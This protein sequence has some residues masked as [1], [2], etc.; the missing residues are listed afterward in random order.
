MPPPVL[1]I[2]MNWRKLIVVLDHIRTVP[3]DIRRARIG[4]DQST[5][6]IRDPLFATD[7]LQ[8]SLDK[9]AWDV[10]QGNGIDAR[11]NVDTSRQLRLPLDT[12]VIMYNVPGDDCTTVEFVCM[13][14][15]GLL[16]DTL[17]FLEPTGLNV[18]EA[19]ITTINNLA[20]NIF[21]VQRANAPLG[22]NELIY[23]QNV[24]EHDAKNRFDPNQSM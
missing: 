5:L 15:I 22:H 3:L 13:D 4:A 2:R 9:L 1:T 14:R 7:D 21:H 24:F 6:Y 20:H 11:S 19:H 12:K 10:S 16:S 17:H 18:K 23:L 8:A